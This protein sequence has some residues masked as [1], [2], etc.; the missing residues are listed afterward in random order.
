MAYATQTDIEEI[1]GVPNVKKWADRDGD[2]VEANITARITKALAYADVTIND[3]LRDSQYTVIPFTDSPL[4]ESVVDVAAKLAAIW[5]Y[6][7]RGIADYDPDTGRMVHKLK[8]TKDSV[9]EWLHCVK[10]G[11]IRLSLTGRN[12][13][14]M[15]AVT[16]DLDS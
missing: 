2:G 3:R 16:H 10:T 1:F 4:P 9:N 15:E 13:N 6:E 11:K 14:Y 5:L 12:H 7:N 8:F